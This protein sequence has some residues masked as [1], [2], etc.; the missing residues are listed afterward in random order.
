MTVLYS[1]MK[2]KNKSRYLV[3]KTTENKI[4]LLPE[5]PNENEK[6]LLKHKLRWR[7]RLQSEFSI[8]WQAR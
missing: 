8:S 6:E 2:E 4:W 1:E 7:Y 5:I 3:R